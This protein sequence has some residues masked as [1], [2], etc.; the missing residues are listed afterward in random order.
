[1]S[2]PACSCFAGH[3]S[4]KAATVVHH[5]ICLLLDHVARTSGLQSVGSCSPPGSSFR[6]CHPRHKRQ[7]GQEGSSSPE[8]ERP[9]K[10]SACTRRIPI[11]LPT[12][13][14]SSVVPIGLA[15]NKL[16]IGVLRKVRATPSDIRNITLISCFL[17]QADSLTAFGLHSSLIIRPQQLLRSAQRFSVYLK[18]I[19]AQLHNNH[20]IVVSIDL[21]SYANPEHTGVARLPPSI[22]RALTPLLTSIHAYYDPPPWTPSVQLDRLLYKYACSDMYLVWT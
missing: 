16:F 11:G 14:G 17:A 3:F 21:H 2:V 20:G 12:E 18:D 10:K 9:A 4:V 8:D 13:P 1:M 5:R 6:G 15:R 19:S 22:L 7:S